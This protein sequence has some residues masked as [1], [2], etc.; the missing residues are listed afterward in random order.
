MVF[1]RARRSDLARAAHIEF[2]L[3]PDGLD[4]FV[5]CRVKNPKQARAASERNLFLP[6]TALFRGLF[7]V[8]WGATFLAVRQ[9]NG[10]ETSGALDHPLL[11]GLTA[12]GAWLQDCVSSGQL[13]QWLRCILSKA[14][15]ADL[16]SIALLR[17]RQL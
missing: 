15:D 17:S 10:L 11:P 6:L 13:T 9:A 14:P 1:A 7:E 2:D 5:G 8:P 3:T 16:P 4:G 12:A